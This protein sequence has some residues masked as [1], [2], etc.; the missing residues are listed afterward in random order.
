MPHCFRRL[1][2]MERSSTLGTGF[3]KVPLDGNVTRLLS[4]ES[5]STETNL[6]A[7]STG[8]F[9]PLVWTNDG[10][11][12]HSARKFKGNSQNPKKNNKNRRTSELSW[13]AAVACKRPVSGTG[14]TKRHENKARKCV[15]C[16]PNLFFL[17]VCKQCP[18]YYI[19]NRPKL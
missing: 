6:P 13:I 16:G 15:S 19:S 12:S 14:A 9:H 7:M 5:T 1:L 2:Q 18:G 11:P 8:L 4:L 10:V 17:T 3:E